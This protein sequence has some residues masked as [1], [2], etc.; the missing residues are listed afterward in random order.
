MTGRY[1]IIKAGDHENPVTIGEVKVFGTMP[2]LI[3]EGVDYRAGAE[4]VIKK[5]TEKNPHWK[6]YHTIWRWHHNHPIF[7]KLHHHFCLKWS[8]RVQGGPKGS[9]M[10]KKI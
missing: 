8:K 2:C 10:Y 4:K 5:K 7:M 3:E 6:K 1:V 9:Q